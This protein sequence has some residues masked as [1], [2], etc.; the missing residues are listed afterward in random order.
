VPLRG[1]RAAGRNLDDA[2]AASLSPVYDA[3]SPMMT[4][5]DALN[6]AMAEEMERDQKV[7]VIGEEVGDYQ[8]GGL[9]RITSRRTL[10]KPKV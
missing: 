8:A 1:S 6:S 4:V 10:N 7:Y 5:R 3:D 2:G 9:L